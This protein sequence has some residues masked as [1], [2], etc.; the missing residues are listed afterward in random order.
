MISSSR[1]SRSRLNGFS[2]TLISASDRQASPRPVPGTLDRCSCVDQSRAREQGRW[3][4]LWHMAVFTRSP[5]QHP[6]PIEYGIEQKEE[7]QE[8]KCRRQPIL[9]ARFYSGD[10]ARDRGE[11]MGSDPSLVRRRHLKNSCHHDLASDR[12]RHRSLL[13]NIGKDQHFAAP[14]C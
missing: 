12:V 2:M 4:F 3:D 8:S 1:L 9:P 5:S 14:G 11:E 6:S 10:A 7:L 13:G